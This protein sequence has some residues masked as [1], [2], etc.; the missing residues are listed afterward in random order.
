MEFHF[1]GVNALTS[2]TRKDEERG[3]VKGGGERGR[4]MVKR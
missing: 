3:G 2:F 1:P 4:E